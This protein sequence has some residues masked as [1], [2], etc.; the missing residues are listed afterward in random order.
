MILAFKSRKPIGVNNKCLMITKMM[1]IIICCV[2]WSLQ[3]SS[4]TNRMLESQSIS[5]LK[6]EIVSLKGLLLSR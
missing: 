1:M 5:E 2:I 3:A 4:A 6:A